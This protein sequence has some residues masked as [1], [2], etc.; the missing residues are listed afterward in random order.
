MALVTVRDIWTIILND[1]F[2]VPVNVNT[3]QHIVTKCDRDHYLINVL[4]Q[5][6]LY[7]RYIFG[8]HLNVL[9]VTLL[10]RNFTD[11][12]FVQFG[13]VKQLTFPVPFM[14]YIPEHEL[15]KLTVTRYVPFSVPY[16]S[17]VIID[18][19]QSMPVTVITS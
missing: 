5:P 9:E 8:I 14:S 15:W 17:E 13:L 2:N 3:Y 18:I 6:D 7:T 12:N 19:V 16:L 4:L 1:Y 11:Q 10:R